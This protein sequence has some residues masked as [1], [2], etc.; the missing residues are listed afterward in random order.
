VIT[1]DPV[2]TRGLIRLCHHR[3]TLRLV[4]ALGPDGSRFAV[5]GRQLGVARQTLK[6]ALEVGVDA[7]WVAR[8]P[9]YGHPLRPEYLRTPRGQ[10]LAPRCED[11]L[12]HADDEALLGRK[13][14]L[15]VLVVVHEGADRFSSILEALATASPRA[16]SRCLDDLVEA[17]WLDRAFVGRRPRYQVPASRRPLAEAATRLAEATSVPAT[18]P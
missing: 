9:G 13:W 6:R 7:G 3:W 2:D 17:G 14:T 18:A 15:P 5:L 16:L 12:A 10:M 11:V 4:V 8:N 1:Q